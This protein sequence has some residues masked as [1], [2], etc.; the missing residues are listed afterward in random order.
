[1][2]KIGG[3]I[4]CPQC[5]NYY[6]PV[7]TFYKWLPMTSRQG[8]CYHA[9]KGRYEGKTPTIGGMEMESCYGCKYANI[10]ENGHEWIECACRLDG[11]IHSPSQGCDK[12]EER[13]YD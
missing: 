13:D 7:C 8:Y 4:Y 1:M 9:I 6:A 5:K 10:Y 3:I 11:K 12:H 2:D